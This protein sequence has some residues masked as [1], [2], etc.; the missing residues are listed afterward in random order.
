MT[1]NKCFEPD[2]PHKQIYVDVI[3]DSI[4]DKHGEV[5]MFNSAIE[6]GGWDSN[7]YEFLYDF[8]IAVL[9]RKGEQ[10]ME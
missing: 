7:G 1:V 8:A 6:L 2:E 3:L 10:W 4:K 5:G 9:E